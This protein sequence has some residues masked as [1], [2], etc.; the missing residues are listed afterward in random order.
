M[1]IF[2]KLS[3]IAVLVIV[4]LQMTSCLK[5]KINPNYKPINEVNIKDTIH[6]ANFNLRLGDTLRVNNDIKQTLVTGTDNLSYQW[7]IYDLINIDR[8]AQVIGSGPTLSYI[9][10]P[11]LV[12][13]NTYRITQKVT[14]KNTGVSSFFQ[15]NL[16]IINDFSK[17][18]VVLE[19]QPNGSDF[20]MILPNEAI[21]RNVYSKVNGTTMPGNPMQVTLTT[22]TV[23]D[24]ISATTRKFYILTDKDGAEL[25]YATLSKKF[26]YSYLFFQSPDV[27]KPNFLDLYIGPNMGLTINNGKAHAYIFGGS[28]GVKKFIGEAIAPNGAGLNYNLAPFAASGAFNSGA[29]LYYSIIV[30]DQT[31]KRFYALQS[32]GSTLSTFPAT[33]S[34]QTFDMNNVGMTMISMVPSATAYNYYAIMRDNTNATYLLQ[35]KTSYAAV[36][37]TAPNAGIITTGKTKLTA[38]DADKITTILQSYVQNQFFYAAENKIY[39]YTPGNNTTVLQYTFPTNEQVTL[40]RTFPSVAFSTVVAATWNG[41][42]GKIY[43]FKASTVSD[44]TYG[45]ISTPTATYTGFKKIQ[46]IQYKL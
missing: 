20:S 14:D 33:A 5:T 19:Q 22:F 24:N 30:Y 28:P 17:G 16:A 7:M 10:N 44:A 9:I 2:Y 15:F 37:G 36:T 8:P 13:G 1:K 4:S 18:Y 26:D 31:G 27:I 34:D 6:T 25:D 21:I 3:I 29:N 40:L 42:E 12:L 39:L 11:P 23:L 41:T 46:D 43:T 32:P 38:P 45:Q 35:F